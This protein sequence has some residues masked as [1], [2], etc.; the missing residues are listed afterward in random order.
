MRI[1]VINHLTLDGVSQAPGGPDEDRRGGF[2]Y[3]GWETPYNDAVMADSLGFGKTT[4][5][6]PTASEPGSGLLLGRRTY[7]HFYGFWPKQK[8][9]PYTEVLNKTRKYVASRTLHEPLPWANSIL[10]HGDAAEA[11]SKLKQET[12]SGRVVVLGSGE[13]VQSLMRANLVDEYML[14]IHPLVLGTGRRLFTDGGA[15]TKLDL[16]D[17]RTTTKGVIIATYRPR[18]D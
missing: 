17:S 11:V 15:F 9:N 6:Q 5:R 7:E 8:D 13:L 2:P 4:Q 12:N 16:V 18:S 14:L 1:V 3:G 10:L